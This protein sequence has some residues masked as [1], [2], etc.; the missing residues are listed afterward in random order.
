M[1]RSEQDEIQKDGPVRMLNAGAVFV[2]NRHLQSGFKK[3]VRCQLCSKGLD[4]AY[5]TIV[6]TKPVGKGDGVPESNGDDEKGNATR[7]RDFRDYTPEE[8]DK[9]LG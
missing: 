2:H 1:Q 5:E 3:A 4:G 6:E 8:A 7:P 9:L